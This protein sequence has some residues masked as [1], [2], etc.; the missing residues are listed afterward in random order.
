MPRL[1][2]ERAWYTPLVVVAAVALLLAHYA[3]LFW[4][5]ARR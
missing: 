1:A 5:V 4:L 3:A 2:P